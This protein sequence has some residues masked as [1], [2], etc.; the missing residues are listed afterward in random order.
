MGRNVENRKPVALNGVLR[1][2][3]RWARSGARSA[4]KRRNVEKRH[5][6]QPIALSAGVVLMSRAGGSPVVG[7][8]NAKLS[9]VEERGEK[10]RDVQNALGV[11]QIAK[12]SK[13]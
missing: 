7:S 3:R 11:M 5:A 13:L 8:E 1:R 4:A 10:R 12:E 9:G 6:E 2:A